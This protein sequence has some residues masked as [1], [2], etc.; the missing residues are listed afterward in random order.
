[1]YDRVRIRT[2]ARQCPA[3]GLG[4]RS[5][6]TERISINNST[7]KRYVASGLEIHVNMVDEL[8]PLHA[9]TVRNRVG[10]VVK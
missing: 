1:M 6:F 9:L 7:I 5:S 10:Q 8:Y 4:K 2:S 3:A